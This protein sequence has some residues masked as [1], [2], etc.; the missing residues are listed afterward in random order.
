[1]LLAIDVGNTNI[2]MGVFEK[3]DLLSTW[4]MATDTGK[5]PDEYAARSSAGSLKPVLFALLTCRA[6]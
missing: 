6:V 4:R 1:M 3:Q 5:M 2:T